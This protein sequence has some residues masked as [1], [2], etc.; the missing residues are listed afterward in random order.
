MNFTGRATVSLAPVGT[1]TTDNGAW[2]TIGTVT[3]FQLDD[4]G[5]SEDALAGP[6][7]IGTNLTVKA[8]IHYVPAETFAPVECLRTRRAIEE[9]A[10]LVR[11]LRMLAKAR[12]EPVSHPCPLPFGARDAK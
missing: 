11:I 7:T 4:D 9:R 5:A 1:P 3:D 12:R 2:T 6:A 10:Q 8:L